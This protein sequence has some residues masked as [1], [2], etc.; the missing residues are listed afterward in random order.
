MSQV[1]K[2]PLGLQDFLGSQNFGKNPSE[3]AQ[4]LIPTLDLFPFLSVYDLETTTGATESVFNDK[5]LAE[6]TVPEGEFWMLDSIGIGVQFNTGPGVA[7]EG[8][9]FTAY[10]QRTLQSSSSALVPVGEIVNFRSVDTSVTFIE[11]HALRF[12]RL[13]PIR[14]NEGINVRA[15]RVDLSGAG[16]IRVY[17]VVR[18]FKFDI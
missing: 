14:P 16:E 13:L 8:A 18:Y 9:T 5:S 10:L 12:E 4:T 6:I 17:P 1:N 2:P 11:F 3:L 15:T 7:G